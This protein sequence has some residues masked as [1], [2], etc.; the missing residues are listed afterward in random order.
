MIRSKSTPGLRRELNGLESRS[1][2]F[3]DYTLSVGAHGLWQVK[4]CWGVGVGWESLQPELPLRGISLPGQKGGSLVPQAV[5]SRLPARR[6]P[7]ERPSY[8]NPLYYL[9]STTGFRIS[10]LPNQRLCSLVRKRGHQEPNW[11]GGVAQVRL[12]GSLRSGEGDMQRIGASLSN[13]IPSTETRW[14]RKLSV[15][16][17]L[18]D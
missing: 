17:W 10:E 12:E 16:Y 2:V 6:P 9:S 1:Q 7:L 4:L 13:T 3:R 5:A 14:R 15:I 11:K 8:M 18:Q